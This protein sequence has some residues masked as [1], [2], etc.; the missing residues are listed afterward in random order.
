MEG[1]VENSVTVPGVTVAFEFNMNV[2]VALEIVPVFTTVI[3]LL[4]CPMIE[5]FKGADVMSW[6]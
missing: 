6:A 5:K 3:R 2:V 1:T 4:F